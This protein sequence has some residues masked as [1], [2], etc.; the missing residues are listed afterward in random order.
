[1]SVVWRIKSRFERRVPGTWK[2]T[3]NPVFV[4][5]IFKYLQWYYIY[6]LRWTNYYC[7]NFGVN[8]RWNKVSKY[9]GNWANHMRSK[10][11]N[12]IRLIACYCGNFEFITFLDECYG[13]NIRWMVRWKIKINDG[14]TNKWMIQ[15]WW[16]WDG[17]SKWMMDGQ[18]NDLNGWTDR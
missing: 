18:M 4:G 9:F 13:L 1:M 6:F 16:T 14:Q 12:Q 3:I 15:W 8:A 10:L 5:G 7:D 17:W 11:I 2:W